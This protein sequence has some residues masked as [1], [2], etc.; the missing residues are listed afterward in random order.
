MQIYDMFTLSSTVLKFY[1]KEEKMSILEKS[2]KL[3]KIKKLQSKNHKEL[4]FYIRE[5]LR[6]DAIIYQSD[7]SR[8]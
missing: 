7:Q 3:I 8:D 4:L 1:Q 6:D 2:K 5:Y